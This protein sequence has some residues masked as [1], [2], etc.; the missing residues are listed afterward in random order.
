MPVLELGFLT[1][2]A[3]VGAKQFASASTS[4]QSSS[5]KAE[6]SVKRLNTQFN[7]TG[8][9]A[10]QLRLVFLLHILMYF[11]YFHIEKA[12]AQNH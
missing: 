7:T 6:G 12:D 8:N 10:S 1:S 3:R 5:Q 9:A 11:F 4:V 2:G